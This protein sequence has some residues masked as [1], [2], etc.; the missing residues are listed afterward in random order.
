MMQLGLTLN[1]SEEFAPPPVQVADA[2]WKPIAEAPKDR[3][4]LVRNGVNLW[5]AAPLT[6]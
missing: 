4:L 1:C 6:K 3:T 2:N 5:F